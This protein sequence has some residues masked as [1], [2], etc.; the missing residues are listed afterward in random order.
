MSDFEIRPAT[1]ADIEA[2][3]SILQEAAS[4]Q[5]AQ[6]APL[7]NAVDLTPDALQGEV[8]AGLYWI[9]LSGDEAVGCL[10]Y[11]LEDPLFWPDAA[12]GEAAYVHRLAV[13]R[14][15]A[16]GALSSAL[17]DWAKAH[18]RERGH[19]FL[20]LDCDAGREKLREFYE[21]HGFTLA[22]EREVGS[23]SVV[24]YEFDLSS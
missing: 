15:H 18:A 3:A 13:R 10:R 20:R 9:A 22:G 24:L 17:L 4:W 1:A 16:G 2:V 6:G 5:E 21:Q 8:S 7:W 19:D 23:H 12:F 11:Q 14:S